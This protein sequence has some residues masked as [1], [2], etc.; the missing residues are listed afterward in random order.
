MRQV[1]VG[2]W[3]YQWRK[4]LSNASHPFMIY[5][6]EQ[7][8]STGWKLHHPLKVLRHVYS[9]GIP[10]G[11]QM[12]KKHIPI[13]VLQTPS[14]YSILNARY[15]PKFKKKNSYRSH[16]GHRMLCHIASDSFFFIIEYSVCPWN[17][18]L[19]EC[20]NIYPC[21][22]SLKLHHMYS[23]GYG[24]QTKKLNALSNEWATMISKFSHNNLICR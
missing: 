9:S 22:F 7:K 12:K 19:M 6:E 21:T 11:S 15:I 10:N 2:Q 18:I 5:I 17:L 20:L 4:R 8:Q 1:C 16:Q 3:H 13:H 24:K 23:T 14:Q